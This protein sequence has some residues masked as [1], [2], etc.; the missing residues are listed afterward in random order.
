MDLHII[1]LPVCGGAESIAVKLVKSSENSKLFSLFLRKVKIYEKRFGIKINDIVSLMKVF[2]K[3]KNLRIFTHNIQA[4]IFLNIF[5]N[6]KYDRSNKYF[7]VIHFD[8]FY[9][10]KIWIVIYILSIKVFKPKLIFVSEYAYTRF[11]KFLDT[12]D[13]DTKVIN[14]AIENKYFSQKNISKNHIKSKSKISIGFIGRYT[15]IKRL[16]LFLEFF[17][18][19]FYL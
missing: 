4:H 5:K 17:L 11:Q 14:N 18:N 7:N 6:L 1:N 13:F 12:K 9:V 10:K 2:L 16:P 3:K 8:A 19:H 15:P